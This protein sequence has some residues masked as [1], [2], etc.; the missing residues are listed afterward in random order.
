MNILY[1]LKI[2]GTNKLSDLVSVIDAAPIDI[3][4][5][6][7]DAIDNGEIEVD[8]DKD[9]VKALKE[10]EEWH[11]PQLANKILRTVQHYAKN[12]TNISKGRLD[13]DIKDPA[14]G[15]GYAW[16]EYL[17][18]LQA[19]IDKGVIIEDIRTIP[20]TKGRPFHRFVF[21]CLPDNDNEEWN[22]RQINKWISNWKPSKV[23]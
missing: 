17:M 8:A 18:T 12:E 10:A 13:G 3:N 14:T 4:L 5:A 9:R 2:M 7:W 23:K 21:L 6:I 19:L 20:K 16:H 11:N 22:S 15:E 1:L